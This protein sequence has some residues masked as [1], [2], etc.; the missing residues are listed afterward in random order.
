MRGSTSPHAKDIIS[1]QSGSGRM[2]NLVLGWLY[3]VL[4]QVRHIWDRSG[5]GISDS[6]WSILR[7][8]RSDVDLEREKGKGHT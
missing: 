5:S 8:E 2:C 3:T 7:D 1:A 6:G 4:N